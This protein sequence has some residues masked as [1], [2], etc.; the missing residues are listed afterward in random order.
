MRAIRHRWP[1]PAYLACARR[2]LRAQ[3]GFALIEVVV[4]AGLLMVVAGGVLAGIDGPSNIS[5][6]NE[7][8]S[9]ASSLAQQDIERM[10]SMPISQLVGYSATTPVTVGSPPQTYSRYSQVVWV[11]DANDTSSCTIPPDDN[12]GDYLKLTSQVTPPG[13]QPAVKIVSLLAPP[14]GSYSQTKGNL[15][16]RLLNQADQPVVGQSVSISGAQSATVATNSEGCAVF[17]LVNQG[18]YT[19]TFSRGG[20]V[21]PAGQTNVSLSTTVNA[22]DNNIVNHKYAQ[23]AGINVNVDTIIPPA[24]TPVSSP[25][26]AVTISNGGIP[27]GTLTF[28]ATTTTQSAWSIT[29]LYPFTDGYGV[30]AGGCASGNPTT[31]GKPAV[32]ATP[33]PGTTASVIV[34]QPAIKV[35]RATGVPNIGN[36]DFPPNTQVT[37]TSIDQNCSE[38]YGP[39]ATTGVTPTSVPNPGVP[40][41]NYKLCATASGAYAQLDT[42]AN[43]NPLGSTPTVPYKNTGGCPP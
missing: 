3:S 16:V 37:Y 34:R 27:T 40:Y 6:R 25:A 20:W 15:S 43:T 24:S 11:R 4:S 19:I 32:V 18:S 36:Y 33:A 2:R 23:A 8:R 7:V 35:S 10:R 5:G 42:F 26:K 17:G 41:G 38:K 1:L 13:N 28:N 12:A 29:N 21:N 22:G 39:Q 30:W 9:Q 14:P 31:Y